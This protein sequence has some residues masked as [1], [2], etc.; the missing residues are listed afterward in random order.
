MLD[1]STAS[2]N[3]TTAPTADPSPAPSPA[4]T[5]TG[6]SEGTPPQVSSPTP[7]S[8]DISN[9]IRQAFGR[10]RLGAPSA[11]PES[12]SGTSTETP[13]EAAKAE[14]ATDTPTEP[15]KQ[16]VLTPE[17]L[18]RKVQAEADRRE[19][20]R[21]KRQEEEDRRNRER[22][23][24]DKDPYAYV[25]EIKKREEEEAARAALDAD[26]I[27]NV[28]A[29]LTALDR[30]VMD[31]LFER[32]PEQVQAD[33]LSRVK[34]PG[35]EGRTKMAAEALKALENHYINQG[36]TKARETLMNDSGFIKMV[37]ARYGGQRIEPDVVSG[38]SAVSGEPRSVDESMNAY[39]RG[40]RRR[41]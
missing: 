30:G 22:E 21:R 12:T 11:T 1:N 2:S 23:L 34:E 37:L 15:A 17:E 39:I 24:R 9:S 26:I 7:T 4:P 32:L 19:A 36:M 25:D 33:I 18:D 14:G 28:S 35:I 41:I 6:G 20:V 5:Q 13:A 3:G 31:P 29:T 8:R 40:G 16:L 27:S 10:N 38:T